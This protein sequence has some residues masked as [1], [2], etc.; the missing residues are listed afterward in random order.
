MWFF[1]T[2]ATNLMKGRIINWSLILSTTFYYSFASP[3]LYTAFWG[4]STN[5]SSS[6]MEMEVV[7]DKLDDS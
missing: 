2:H 1:P 3:P 5:T 6:K 7:A 4:H